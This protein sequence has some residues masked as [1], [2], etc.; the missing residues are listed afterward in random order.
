MTQQP[1]V[2]CSDSEDGC[3]IMPL[4]LMD[5]IGIIKIISSDVL[6]FYDGFGLT[7]AHRQNIHNEKDNIFCPYLRITKCHL[8]FDFPDRLDGNIS[9]GRYFNLDGNISHGRYFNQGKQHNMPATKNYT[10]QAHHLSRSC[11]K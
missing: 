8:S 7:I 5:C 2:S 11:E 10:A 9:H 3:L 4:K 1:V 6:V